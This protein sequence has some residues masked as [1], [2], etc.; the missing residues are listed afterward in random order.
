VVRVGAATGEILRVKG[1]GVPHIHEKGRRGD[2]LVKLHIN[3]P[4]KL[5]KKAM[6]L[7]EGLQEEGL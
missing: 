6:A 2:M 1:R 7:V 5:S 3:M 4:K